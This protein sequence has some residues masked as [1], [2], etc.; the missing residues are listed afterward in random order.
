SISYLVGG[1]L[2][3]MSFILTSF[4]A[5][6]ITSSLYLDTINLFIS[7]GAMIFLLFYT[8]FASLPEIQRETGDSTEKSK[9]ELLEA[10]IT[11]LEQKITQL[12]NVGSN[13]D[14][15]KKFLEYTQQT[16]APPSPPEKV[17]GK[18]KKNRNKS[19]AS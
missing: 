11:D 1:L 15:I 6:L 5:D 17:D 19:H 9:I 10:K 18:P 14:L 4:Q 16:A 13:I 12:V 8:R 3:L 7:V 2:V